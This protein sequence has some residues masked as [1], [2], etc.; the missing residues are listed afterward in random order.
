M[1]VRF[2]E[3]DHHAY[4]VLGLT[5]A[6][7]D[8]SRSVWVGPSS[9]FLSAGSRPNLEAF[10]ESICTLELPPCTTTMVFSCTSKNNLSTL[11]LSVVCHKRI[12]FSRCV[13][14]GLDASVKLRAQRAPLMR[15]LFPSATSL[16]G[17]RVPM[18]LGLPSPVPSVLEFSRLLDG[19]FPTQLAC[20]V[21][22]RRHPWDSKNSM[23][24]LSLAQ[25]RYSR[26]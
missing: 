15:F 5:S 3:P 14:H 17:S 1:T 21:S 20:L 26:G 9:S 7:I 25:S 6:V 16:C 10:P 8:S 19:L 24:S 11:S 2:G 22:Y 12:V 23:V 4:H 13:A 18:S